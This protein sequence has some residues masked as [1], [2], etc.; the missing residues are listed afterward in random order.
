MKVKVIKTGKNSWYKIGEVFNV[1]EDI[2]QPNHYICIETGL[3]ID[4]NHVQKENE[5]NN[6]II[7]N[8]NNSNVTIVYINLEDI[9]ENW[10]DDEN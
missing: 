2:N 1:T 7:T 4:K 10:F 3:Y 5:Q 8:S 9:D 6:K